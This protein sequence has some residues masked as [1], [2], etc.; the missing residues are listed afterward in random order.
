MARNNVRSKIGENSAF[1]PVFD[2][3]RE[4]ANH[5][6][7]QILVQFGVHNQIMNER[8]YDTD[9]LEELGLSKFTGTNG[10]DLKAAQHELFEMYKHVEGI[11]PKMPDTTNLAI[12]INRLGETIGLN[13]NE[14]SFLH[15]R[16]MASRHLPLR[17]CIEHLGKGVDLLYVV[18]VFAKIL[19][20][21]HYAMEH[22]LSSN[23]KLVRA[24]LISISPGLVSIFGKIQLLDGLGDSLFGNHPD[25]LAMFQDNFTESSQPK[26]TDLDYPHLRDDTSVLLSYLKE[27][28]GTKQAGVNILI[29]GTPGS[30]KT[31]YVKMLA[32]KIDSKLYEIATSKNNGEPVKK[33]ERF[34]SFRLSQ[35]ILENSE[36]N[37]I[38]LFDEVEDV[39]YIGDDEVE[40]G[41]GNR[42]GIKG[43]VNKLLEENPV[44]SFWLSNSL[45]CLDKAF[46]RRF[47]YVIE[48]KTP[49]RSVRTK[50]LNRYLANMPVSESWMATMSEHEFLNP[51]VVERVARVV[52]T[53][54]LDQSVVPVEKV[55]ERALGNTL[56]AM[57]LP[58]SPKNIGQSLT[59]YRLDVLNT[60]CNLEDLYAGLKEHGK[61]RLCLFGPP[62][63]GK[64]AFGRYLADRLDR[65]LLIKRASD[66]LSP[67]IGATEQNMA[68]MFCE[69]ELDDA[70]LQLDEADSFLRDRKG[71]TR[72]WEVSEVNEMLTQME[73]F[74]GVFI[75]STNLMDSLDAAA[76][77]RFD[78]KV[79]FDYLNQEQA[80][81]MFQ[82]TLERLGL[83]P[84]MECRRALESM[85]LLTPGDFANVARQAKLRRITSPSDLLERLS[86]E[87]L[88]KPEGRSRSIGF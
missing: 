76:L 49:P 26:L 77:R 80:W 71:A 21:G 10:F 16:V 1:H 11:I 4:V 83:P 73:T 30:G 61:G 87:C 34:R 18:S 43:W 72:S 22:A 60:D 17:T 54:R 25:L 35:H 27:C 28:I 78:I 19:R 55:I 44:P 45:H 36:G 9:V 40:K 79:R 59:G 31:E 81:N 8:M 50:V 65:P 46:V 13:Q 29:Y 67:F 58:R 75:A 24:G 37:P 84:A 85:S 12:N 74:K 62:G 3:Y 41:I 2:E 63:T 42:S 68:R 88:I 64:T 47:D 39:F 66:I 23:G 52:E 6:M 70:V 56:E 57:G 32:N 33:A 69:A 51:G 38:L 14:M 53:A 7:L 86:A 20:V 15:L 5:L 48:I 82:D